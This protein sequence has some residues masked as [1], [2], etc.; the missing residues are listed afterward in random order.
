M[1]NL[2]LR[3]QG[4]VHYFFGPFNVSNLSSYIEDDNPLDSRMCLVQPGENDVNGRDLHVRWLHGSDSM[5]VF[6]VTQ[7]ELKN[8]C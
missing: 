8:I 2:L 3:F 7:L 4:R 1:L 6:H 5:H